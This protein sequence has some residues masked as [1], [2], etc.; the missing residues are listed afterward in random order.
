MATYSVAT[1]LFQNEW[2]IIGSFLSRFQSQARINGLL[3]LVTAFGDLI[4][5]PLIPNRKITQELINEM[6]SL[7]MLGS[8]NFLV[9]HMTWKLMVHSLSNGDR[10]VL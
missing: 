8:R 5:C 9:D 10:K 2:N 3:F 4:A 6:K 7:F 1:N